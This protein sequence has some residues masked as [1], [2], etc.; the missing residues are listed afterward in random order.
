[1]ITL[2]T[3]LDV[4]TPVEDALK[5]LFEKPPKLIDVFTSRE[6]GDLVKT[7]LDVAFSLGAWSGR[8]LP[9][10]SGVLHHAAWAYTLQLSLF[11][12][13]QEKSRHTHGQL[14]GEI[15]ARLEAAV[16]RPVWV[17]H[18]TLASLNETTGTEQAR[19]EDD[20][21]VSAMIFTGLVTIRSDSMRLVG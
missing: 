6:T 2:A 16:L 10:A 14:R 11:T 17:R 19:T 8:W 5:S 9:D 4:Q 13:R 7:R 1:M 20:L 21:D 18:H 12:S 15:R 3:L